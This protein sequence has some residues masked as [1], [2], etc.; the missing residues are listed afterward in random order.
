M[1]QAGDPFS[2][3]MIIGAFSTHYYVT[4]I[5]ICMVTKGGGD[6]TQYTPLAVGAGNTL[7]AAMR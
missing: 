1:G 5:N 4:P 2:G 3:E 7:F 6:A